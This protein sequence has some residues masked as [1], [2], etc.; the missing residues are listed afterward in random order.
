MA[1]ELP[2]GWE[3]PIRALAQE[4]QAAM[5][6]LETRKSSQRC[7]GALASTLPELFGGS[8]DLTGSNGTRWNGADDQRYLSYGVR[9]FAMTAM[10]NGMLLHGGFR[11][12][13]GTFLVFMEY[14][15]N[16]VRPAALM[17]IPNIF[18]YTHDSVAVGE[19]GPTH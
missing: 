2:A 17:Q 6:P 12:F 9:E 5:E 7:L 15:R 11:T 10:T 3:A 4:A 19:D 13:T 8:A 1:G 14:A 18:V 16:A